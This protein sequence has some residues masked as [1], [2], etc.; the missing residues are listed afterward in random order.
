MDDLNIQVEA[1]HYFRPRYIHKERWINYWY[2]LQAIFE[3]K[4]SRILEIGIGNGLVLDTLRKV[5]IH[6]E[7][8]D[9]DPSLHPDIVASAVRLPMQ[10]E[11]YDFVLCAEVLEHLPPDQVKA[12]LEEIFRV[13]RDCALIT[14]PYA[15]SC[16]TFT[17]KIPLLKKSEWILK[18]PHFWKKHVFDGQHYWEVGKQGFLQKDIQKMVEETGFLVQRMSTHSDDPSHLFVLLKKNHSVS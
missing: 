7:T 13:T 9:I 5:G 8:V 2:Q 1:K 16:I 10:N 4:A 14:L 6:V 12:A 18:I 17:F 11:A 15:G 3:S